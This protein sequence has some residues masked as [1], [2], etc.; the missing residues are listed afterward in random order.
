M[1]G[2]CYYNI[3]RVYWYRRK[4]LV[5]HNNSNIEITG[6]VLLCLRPGAWL[7]DEVIIGITLIHLC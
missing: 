6:E 3:I 7:N 5:A 4:V 2:F 1:G